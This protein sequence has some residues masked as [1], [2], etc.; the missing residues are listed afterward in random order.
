[1][2]IITLYLKR[3]GGA[4][5]L[6]AGIPAIFMA[7]MTIWAVILNEVKFSAGSSALLTVI[8]LCVLIVALWILIEGV[9]K[10][11]SAE[12]EPAPPTAPETV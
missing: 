10:F 11:F 7:V 6:I 2:I 8:N 9:V 3:R 4:K 5:W 12:E 1:L